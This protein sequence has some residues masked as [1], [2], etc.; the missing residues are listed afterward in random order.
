LERIIIIV[1]TIP[2]QLHQFVIFFAY[3]SI[4]LNVQ[5]IFHHTHIGSGLSNIFCF[6]VRR[7]FE[8][9]HFLK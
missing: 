4:K 5:D 1:D 6:E 8:E 3:E 7:F 2:K 9:K